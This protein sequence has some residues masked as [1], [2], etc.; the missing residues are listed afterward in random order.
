MRAENSVR[1]AFNLIKGDGIIT[2]IVKTSRPCR[3]VAG[4]LLS[5]LKFPTVLQ[6]G[7][8]AGR[9]KAVAEILVAMPA[10]RERRSI[11]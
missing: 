6:V 1:D 11:I 5:D 9:P 2:S 8:D 10:L 7:G 3:F 4:H